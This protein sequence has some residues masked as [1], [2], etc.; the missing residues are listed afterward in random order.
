MFIDYLGNIES[1]RQVIVKIKM[2]VSIFVGYDYRN[3]ENVDSWPQLSKQNI[4]HN[5]VLVYRLIMLFQR[6]IRSS[7]RHYSN[8]R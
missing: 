1:Y 7:E 5:I 6:T 3:P 8:A 2:E 4:F